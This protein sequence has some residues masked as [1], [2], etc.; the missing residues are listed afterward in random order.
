MQRPIENK[1]FQHSLNK[2][3]KKK[4]LKKPPRGGGGGL[5]WPVVDHG[6]GVV[7]VCKGC[8]FGATRSW[9]AVSLRESSTLTSLPFLL[10][11]ESSRSFFP[12]LLS[13]DLK[14][15]SGALGIAG[16]ALWA[17]SFSSCPVLQEQDAAH[18]QVLPRP[19]RQPSSPLV[20]SQSQRGMF[21]KYH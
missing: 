21:L 8:S 2:C 20:H 18:P 5:I 19:L 9:S 13:A 10:T 6:L 16:H 11:T 3:K 7:A 12:T 4:N 15:T 17:A 14:A 1:T